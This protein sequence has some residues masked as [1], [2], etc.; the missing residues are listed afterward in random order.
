M[1]E[2][3]DGFLNYTNR[4]GWLMMEICANFFENIVSDIVGR[5]CC[6]HRCTRE[7]SRTKEV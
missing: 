7:P 6:D 3:V 4:M 1:E 2:R 5:V